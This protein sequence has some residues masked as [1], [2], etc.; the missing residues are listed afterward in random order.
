M[1]HGNQSAA[2]LRENH[3]C[4]RDAGICDHWIL[5][6]ELEPK[7]P[8]TPDF[9]QGVFP[10]LQEEQRE[11][12][13]SAPQRAILEMQ[14]GDERF[15]YAFTLDPFRRT[16]QPQTKFARTMLIGVTVYCFEVWKDGQD[17]YPAKDF[18]VPMYQL[19]FAADGAFILPSEEAYTA[20]WDQLAPVLGLSDTEGI[21]P[22]E[23]LA[24]L[25]HLPELLPTQSQAVMETFLRSYLE[26]LSPEELHEIA[27]FFRRTKSGDVQLPPFS[28]PSME[29]AMQ[30]FEDSGQ[31]QKMAESASRVQAHLETLDWPEPLKRISM[32]FTDPTLLRNVGDIMAWSEDSVVLQQARKK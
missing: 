19:E 22:T 15:I 32:M 23:V 12:R 17:S 10:G 18:F 31:I 27:E 13:L 21:I 25:E 29:E 3:A 26:T 11:Y 4:Y 28:T 9:H 1:V 16:E 2:H 14:E 8:G 30:A 24:K 7:T 6:D 5:W 20:V